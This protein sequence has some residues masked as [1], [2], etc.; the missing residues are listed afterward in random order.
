M[1]QEEFPE[2]SEEEQEE[3][4]RELYEFAELMLDVYWNSKAKEAEKPE[5]EPPGEMGFR[6]GE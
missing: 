6:T 2:M 4:E 5:E 1:I 3:L